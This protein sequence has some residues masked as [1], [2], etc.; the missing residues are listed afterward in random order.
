M[1]CRS[2][3]TPYKLDAHRGC[4]TDSKYCDRLAINLKVYSHTATYATP[5]QMPF[6]LLL[7]RRLPAT[8]CMQ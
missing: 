2:E 4:P 1:K 3:E 8:I 7:S 5:A 6:W